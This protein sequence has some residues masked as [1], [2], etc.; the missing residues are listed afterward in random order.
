M[1]SIRNESV[2]MLFIRNISTETSTN[3]PSVP[4]PGFNLEQAKKPLP[5][6]KSGSKPKAA[7]PQRTTLTEQSASE[8]LLEADVKEAGLERDAA[9]QDFALSR[10]KK[11]KKATVWQ[12]VKHGVQHFWDGTKLLGAEIK[13]SW[14]LALKMAAGYELSRRERRQVSH[15]EML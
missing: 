6:S 5:E 11:E 8:K 2:S 4:P 3:P 1:R 9:A 15:W 14:R 13:I 12:K 10:E 7:T